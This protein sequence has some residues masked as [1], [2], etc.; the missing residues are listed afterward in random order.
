M[1]ESERTLVVRFLTI[2]RKCSIFSKTTDGYNPRQSFR[3]SPKSAE[4]SVVENK[5]MSQSLPTLEG[6]QRQF[7]EI[8]ITAV[9]RD[10]D[11]HEK[12]IRVVEETT[13]R[14]NFLLYLTM[15]G[16]LVSLFNLFAIV[17]LIAQVM[18]P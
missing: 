12:R 11:D 10:I 1:R 6:L 2:S 14:F 17:A 8:Q 7:L 16:G 5:T 18:E 15:G 13:T 3:V 9:Q 4:P